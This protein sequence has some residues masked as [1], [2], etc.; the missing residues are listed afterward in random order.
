MPITLDPSHRYAP[1]DRCIYC[2]K[3]AN[4]VG[5][6]DEHIIPLSLGGTRV[7]PKASCKQCAGS[8]SRFEL[9]VAKGMWDYARVQFGLPSRRPN[10]RP[11]FFEME[12]PDLTIQQIPIP[13][14]PSAVLSFRFPPAGI[15][16]DL[17]MN[18]TV[19]GQVVIT[20]RSA[21]EADRSM[22][23]VSRQ[24][25]L[26]LNPRG[27]GAVP[28]A[29]LLAKVAHSYAVGELG[30]AGLVPMLGPV[31]IGRNPRHILHWVGSGTLDEPAAKA[32][33]EIGMSRQRQYAGGREFWM[34]RL[35]LFANMGA[36]THTW[37]SA[38]RCDSLRSVEN[39][40]KCS[41]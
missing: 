6:T 11:Q 21:R 20:H 35:R 14:L 26:R 24:G 7:L 19:G 17:P 2:G 25:K 40:H 12:T 38:S 15:L 18:T 28:F 3:S 34:V 1:V 9:D 23:E 37:W 5:L 13:A 39:R 27:F 30:V 32:L 10:K 4:Q 29:Q 16:F 31:I 41:I 8:T 36:P 22:R 33:H